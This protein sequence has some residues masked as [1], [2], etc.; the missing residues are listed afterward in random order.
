MR[1]V[2]DLRR[3]SD[4]DNGPALQPLIVRQMN[5]QRIETRA[6]FRFENSCDCNRIERISRES[7][8]GFCWERDNL[9][10]RSSSTTALCPGFQPAGIGRMPM[11]RAATQVAAKI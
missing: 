1:S 11:A 9:A 6:L 2:F 5:N 3:R 8:N 7:V 10:F 4:F